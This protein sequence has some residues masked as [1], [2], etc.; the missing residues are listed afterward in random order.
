LWLKVTIIF[1]VLWLAAN[2]AFVILDIAATSV[3]GFIS[4]VSVY[5]I[6]YFLPVFMSFKMGDFV[7][8]T[9]NDFEESLIVAD[10]NKDALGEGTR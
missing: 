2:T 10:E 3:I 4:T 9:T 5:Y 1:S 8:K 7:A 6:T